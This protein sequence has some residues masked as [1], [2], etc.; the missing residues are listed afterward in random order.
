MIVDDILT[1]TGTFRSIAQI[2]QGRTPVGFCIGRY[3]MKSV[4]T[5]F[6]LLAGQSRY[7]TEDLL[8]SLA[9]TSFGTDYHVVLVLPREVSFECDPAHQSICHVDLADYATPEFA[10]AAGIRHANEQGIGHRQL[11][12]LTHDC[13]VTGSGLGAFFMPFTQ[14][15]DVGIVGVR[16]VRHSQVMRQW[17]AAR[18]LLFSWRLSL[19]G[20]ESPPPAVLD[21]FLVLAGTFGADLY[22][23]QL[24]LPPR[25]QDWPGSYGMYL[26]WV[27]HL[28]RYNVLSWGSSERP[29]PP[30]YVSESDTGRVHVAPQL[31]RQEFRIYAPV[32]ACA[33]YGAMELRE[34]YKGLRGEPT[35]LTVKYAPVV[36]GA[37]T[38]DQN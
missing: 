8:A 15:D 26:S 4:D 13:L 35:Q 2:P 32:R 24:L 6:V 16:D 34:I 29:M 22:R 37:R 5:V 30:L 20:W 27:A 7:V 14:S 23:R 31:L 18:S 25:H 11:V 33:A 38:R 1:E 3:L 19:D 12:L 17:R 21:S 10:M 28:L 36:T 9:W